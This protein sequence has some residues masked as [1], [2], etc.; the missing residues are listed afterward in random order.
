M[1]ENKELMLCSQKSMIELDAFFVAEAQR[2][3]AGG[4]AASAQPPEPHANSPRAPAGAQ[5]VP[6]GS[7]TTV[8]P[9]SLQDANVFALRSGGSANASPPAY[10]RRASGA[11]MWVMA[12]LG[13]CATR[14]NSAGNLD[15][16]AGRGHEQS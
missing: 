12:R 9:A 11:K 8:G 2:T 10:I 4:G 7:I 14:K 6:A 16:I 3:L 15:L 13:S 1:E 5:D